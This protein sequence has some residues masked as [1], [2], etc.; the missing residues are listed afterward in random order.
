MSHDDTTTGEPLGSERDADT[1]EPRPLGINH[2]AIEVGDVDEAVAFYRGL[3]GFDLRGQTAEMA[4]LDMGDQFIAL[5]ESPEPATGAHAHFGLVVDD[6]ALVE[7]RLEES[8]IER[9]DTSGLD[10]EDPWGNRIQ[11]VG[12]ERVQFTKAAHVLAG[13]DA[14][15]L[16]KTDDAIGEL[17]E[18]GLAPEE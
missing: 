18:K 17:A 12:Y 6:P 11:V 14:D 15:D 7:R 10:F 9:L 5:A 13:M 1:P 2:V 16:E 8:G 4:F 3:F